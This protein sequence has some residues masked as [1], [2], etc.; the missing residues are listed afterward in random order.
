M[1]N[2]GKKITS[3]LFWRFG[4]RVL[5]QGV[6]FVVSLIVSRILGPS[7]YGMVSLLL[8]FINLSEVFLT[9]GFGNSLIQKKDSDNLDFS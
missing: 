6:T 4:E 2:L 9:A 1:S 5:A 7:A 8:V 3:G